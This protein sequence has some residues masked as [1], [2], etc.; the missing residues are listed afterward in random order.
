MH[1]CCLY[2]QHVSEDTAMITNQTTVVISPE[3][4]EMVK[5]ISGE[6]NKLTFAKNLQVVTQKK[7][8]QCDSIYIDYFFL[9]TQIVHDRKAQEV[10]CFLRA[11]ALRLGIQ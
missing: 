6:P 2:N 7:G 9:L 8:F 5:E 11:C 10:E 3:L 1:D 4:C